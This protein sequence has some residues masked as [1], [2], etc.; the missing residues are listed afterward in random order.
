MSIVNNSF[1]MGNPNT[2][3]PLRFTKPVLLSRPEQ[4]RVYADIVSRD[5][6][7]IH[8][9]VRKYIESVDSV[10]HTENPSQKMDS[11]FAKYRN[12]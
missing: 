12:Q 2:S 11:L 6:G 7:S 8:E 3:I 1:M 4:E 9:S 5:I 10:E